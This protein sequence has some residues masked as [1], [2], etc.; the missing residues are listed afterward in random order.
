MCLLVAILVRRRP[1]VNR[2]VLIDERYVTAKLPLVRIGVGLEPCGGQARV[3]EVEAGSAV[4]GTARR[5]VLSSLPLQML[6][7]F[8][9]WYD[10][11]YRIIM[12]CLFGWKGN[13]LPYPGDMRALLGLEIAMVIVLAIVEYTRLFLGSRG[14]KTETVGPLVW[15]LPRP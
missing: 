14:N 10:L 1:F 7:F 2:L 13:W 11:L 4:D 3:E 8:N 12:L 6:F 15:S 9:Q 5:V